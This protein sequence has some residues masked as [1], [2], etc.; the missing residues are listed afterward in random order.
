[1]N[2]LRLAKFE[3]SLWKCFRLNFN[4]HCSVAFNIPRTDSSLDSCVEVI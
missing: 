4:R 3:V 2:V 1:M